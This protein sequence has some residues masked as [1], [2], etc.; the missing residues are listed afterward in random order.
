MSSV[1]RRQLRRR[2]AT[3]TK[4]TLNAIDNT[5]NNDNCNVQLGYETSFKMNNSGKSVTKE[6]FRFKCCVDDCSVYNEPPSQLNKNST[7]LTA[8]SMNIA[9]ESE[10]LF[11]NKL[12]QWALNNKVTHKC[13]NDI[14]S[15]IKPKFPFLY[16]DAR[17]ILGTPRNTQ[18][19]ALD[20]GEMVYFGVEKE[21]L[22][23]KQKSFMLAFNIDGIPLF[24]SSSIEFWPILAKIT[25]CENKSPFVVAIFCGR[26]KPMPL[27]LFLNEFICELEIL[28]AKGNVKIDFF[29]CDAPARSYLKC[30]RGHTSKEG[31]E[32]CNIQTVYAEKKHYYPVTTTNI[33]HRKDSDFLSGVFGKHIYGC[34]PLLKLRLGMV[35]QFVL[36]PMHLIYLGI[37]KRLLVKYILEGK[38]KHK[39]C[40]TSLAVVN[41]KIKTLKHPYDF[42]RRL[43]PLSDA[44]RWKAVE[45]RMFTLYFGIVVLK[46]NISEMQYQHFLLLHVAATIMSCEKLINTCMHIAE[47]CITKFVKRCPAVYGKNFVVYN[48]HSLLHLC[49]DV[50]K[51]GTINKFSCFEYE[52]MLGKLKSYVRGK[53]LPLQQISNRIIELNNAA[54]NKINYP[55]A[56]NTDNGTY[57]NSRKLFLKNKFSISIHRPNNIV[58]LKKK[59]YRIDKIYFLNDEYWCSATPFKFMRNIYRKP[60]Q[61]SK[62]GIFYVVGCGTPENFP[63]NSIEYK[64]VVVSHKEGYVVFPLLHTI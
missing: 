34:S 49:D 43:R 47:K 29:S 64:C 58:G 3:S 6:T 9:N 38:R 39:I 27:S 45:F 46:N 17:T 52:N 10:D 11:L 60:I 24:N 14:I 55:D 30:V 1:S 21:L 26:G 32:R 22:K 19:I 35:T 20:N 44:K 4:N 57:F 12:K 33:R 53:R 61:S 42:T 5:D 25:N 37:M 31:C 50:R 8:D 41:H 7:M 36:D 16:K 54:E 15:L 51:Y 48:V 28:L 40:R 63:A 56:S 13:L 23:T 2:I 62:I 59:I 18:V